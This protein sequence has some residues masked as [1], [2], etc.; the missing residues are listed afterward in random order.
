[1]TKTEFITKCLCCDSCNFTAFEEFGNLRRVTSDSRHF[2]ENGSLCCC[3]DCGLVQKPT[4]PDLLTELDYVYSGYRPYH[5]GDGHEQK[6][7]DQR[8]GQMLPRSDVITSKLFDKLIPSQDCNSWIDIGCGTGGTLLAA[9]RIS[10]KIRLYGYDISGDALPMLIGIPRFEK[11]FTP[12]EEPVL[13]SFD[14]ISAIHVL[15][16]IVNPVEWLHNWAERLSQSGRLV[17][18]V[19]DVRSNPFDLVVA[20]HVTHFTNETLRTLVERAGFDIQFLEGGIVQKELTAVARY[21]K[22]SRSE[23]TI[24]ADT[25]ESS[26]AMV[27]QHLNWLS[28]LVKNSN[29]TLASAYGGRVGLWGSSNAAAWLSGSISDP[30]DFFVDDD[31]ARQ[32]RE[33]MGKPIIP[34]AAIPVGSTVIIGLTPE[35]SKRIYQNAYSEDYN[36]ILPPSYM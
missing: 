33:F 14:I 24:V 20:D 35:V 10:D 13:N 22:K 2:K 32:G 30:A 5:Q 19:C 15:E 17:V 6:V 26:V 18:Q 28:D 1:M 36:L 16:H 11:L 34:P 21:T 9:S 29:S 4:S 3:M 8:T 7:F 23:P 31:P 12:I 25:S 27:R